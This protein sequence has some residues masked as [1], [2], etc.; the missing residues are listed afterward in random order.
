LRVKIVIFDDPSR[1]HPRHQVVFGDYGTVGLDQRHEYAEA[2]AE[3]QR[4]AFGKISRRRGTIMNGPN[5]KLAGA[6]DSG[7]HGPR[8][9]P[10]L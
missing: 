4:P 2:S 10:T 9:Y 6:S 8:L 5:S 7:F 3:L 1:P